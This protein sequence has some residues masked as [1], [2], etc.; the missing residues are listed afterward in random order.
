MNAT[1]PTSGLPAWR[2]RD[3]AFGLLTASVLMLAIVLLRPTLMRL[4]Q[5]VVQTW[6]EAAALPALTHATVLPP[7]STA[8]LLGTT[9]AVLA[10]YALAGRWHERLHP[11]RVLVRALCLIQASACLF[12]AWTPALFPYG[13]EQH[14]TGLLWMGAD[15][16]TALPL[17]LMLGWGMLKLPWA[18]RVLGSLLVLAYFVVWVPHQVLLHAWVLAHGTVL[19]MPVLMLCLGPVLNGWLFVALYAWLVSLTP[20]TVPVR[21]SRP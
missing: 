20:Q 15:L 10:L 4:W 18:L 19:F 5:A 14:L 8:L 3:G 16:L 6:S 9:T 1:A 17:M 12:F 13:I 21:R 7:P 2:W 11:L